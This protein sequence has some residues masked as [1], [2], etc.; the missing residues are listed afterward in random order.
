MP[1]QGNRLRPRL[2]RALRGREWLVR[3]GMLERLIWL[4]LKTHGWPFRRSKRLSWG[5][6][7]PS[8]PL[9]DITHLA[10]LLVCEDRELVVGVRWPSDRTLGRFRHRLLR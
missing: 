8:L 5:D 2:H 6:F 3:F 1:A 4:L 10:W 7:G 9:T